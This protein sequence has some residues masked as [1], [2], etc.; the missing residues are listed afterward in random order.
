MIQFEVNINT[1]SDADALV[2]LT[3]YDISIKFKQ[4][5]AEL[6]VPENTKACIAVAKAL[7]RLG[8]D[9]Q[10][11]QNTLPAEFIN[12]AKL[13]AYKLYDKI[14]DKSGR[15]VFDDVI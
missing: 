10:M 13:S 12:L 7:T 4:N 3:R 2:E 11:M 8:Y 6:N 15:L 1:P 14:I 5:K 9:A